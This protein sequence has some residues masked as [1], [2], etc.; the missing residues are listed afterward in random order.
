MT[1]PLS[2]KRKEGA[3]ALRL[4]TFSRQAVNMPLPALQESP[5]DRLSL[6]RARQDIEGFFR[7]PGKDQ[8]VAPPSS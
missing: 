4:E 2:Q 6:K 8:Y 1:G 5:T 3:E 7:T